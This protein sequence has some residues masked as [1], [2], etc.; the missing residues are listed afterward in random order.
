MSSGVIGILIVVG[1]ALIATFFSIAESSRKEKARFRRVTRD[2][3]GKPSEHEYSAEEFESI[4]HYADDRPHGFEVDDITWHDLDMDSVY[5]ETARCMSSPGDDVLWEMMRHPSFDT[6]TL[7]ERDRIANYFTENEEDRFRSQLILSNVGRMTLMS[8]YD[9]MVRLRDA[10][11]IG[12][13]KFAVLALIMIAD[14]VFMFIYPM[15]AVLCLIPIIIVNIAVSLQMKNKTDVYI[16]SFQCVL[17]F[18]SAADAFRKLDIEILRP[19][20]EKMKKDAAALASFRRG[21]IFVTSSAQVANGLLDIFLEYI[22]IFLHV[23]LLKFDQMLNAYRGHEAECMDLIENIGTI[24]ACISIASFRESCAGK[25]CRPV[26]KANHGD[27]GGGSFSELKIQDMAHPL[28]TD[29]VTNSFDMRGGNLVTGSNASGKST[30]LKGVAISV[31]LAQSIDTVTASSY[32]GPFTRVMTSMALADNLMGGESY[33]IVEIKSLKRILDAA[34]EN[35]PL[36]CII[37]EVLRG[38]NT[39]ERIAASSQIL[40]SLLAPNVLSFAATH[41]IELS[42]M[43]DGIYTNWHFEEEVREHDVVF[44]YELRPGRTTTRN[45][46]KLLEV[47]DYDPAIVDGARRSAEEFEKTGEWKL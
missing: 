14:I 5:L 33:F 35:E 27:G 44:N 30:F 20:T 12:A 29:P 24:D 16:R 32:E 9:Y 46:I 40:K 42:Y 25:W 39:I 34:R 47:M 10:R 3:W 4:S 1:I 36:L 37:D 38:T 23:D 11:R 43:L 45:A 22:K 31:L 28:L 26:L 41:D 17:R 21:S 13:A 7:E 2:S 8:M 6:E 15:I 18:L 19:Y